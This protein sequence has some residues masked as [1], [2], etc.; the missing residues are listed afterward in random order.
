MGNNKNLD[1]VTNLSIEEIE[2]F[3]R[4]FQ[5][6]IENGFK[7]PS[8]TASFSDIEERLE[9]LMTNTRKTY[10]DSLSQYLSALNEKEVIKSKK[11]CTEREEL[12]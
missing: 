5:A 3:L 2:H 7:N 9:Y 12:I 10:L 11:A 6:D 1:S 8:E 4:E